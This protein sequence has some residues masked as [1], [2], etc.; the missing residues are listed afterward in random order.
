[1]S[2]KPLARYAALSGYGLLSDSLGLDWAPLMRSVGLDPAGLAVQDRWIPAAVVARLLEIS[3][4]ASGREDFGVRLAEF[5]RLANWGPLAL[6]VREE[7]DVRSVLHMLIS[8]EQTYN[9]SLNIR[10]S[11]AEGLAV[12]HMDLELGEPAD[13]RQATD[14]AVGAL[15][16][17]HR[18]LHGR[19]WQ[20]LSVCFSHPAPA[21]ITSYLQIFGCEVQF[22]HPFA[23]IVLRASDLAAP[24]K[25]ADPRLRPYAHQFLDS[26]A[27]PPSTDVTTVT[28]VRE[29]IEMLLPTGRCSIVQVARSLGVDRRTL[30]RRL[31][32]S[33]ET[34][35]SLLNAVRVEL[36]ELLVLNPRRSLSEITENLGFSESSAFSRWFRGQFGCSPTEWRIGHR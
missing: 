7:P 30:H 32:D 4:A 24:N 6:V 11:E 16:D 3:A 15:H 28:R 17:I 19:A 12:I 2:F 25:M 14:L 8:Y 22:Q 9:Q 5:R 34:F 21:D 13:T 20:P 10:L 26:I 33:G 31:A 29:L 27:P 36:A 1:V 23:G 35:S 18:R